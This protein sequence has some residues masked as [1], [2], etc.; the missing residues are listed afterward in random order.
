MRMR[1]ERRDEPRVPCVDLLARHPARLVHQVDEAEVARGEHDDVLTGHVV[2]GALLLVRWAPGRLAERGADGAVVLVTADE[3]RDVGRFERPGDEVVEPVAVSLLEGCALRLAVVGEDD[4]LVRAGCVA[5]RTGDAAELVVELAQRLERVGALQPGVVGDLVV[6]RERR[7]DRGPP[8]HHVRQHR[9]HDQ[10]AHDDAHRRAHEGVDAAAVPARLHVAATRTERGRPLEQHL[11]DE[12]H[13]HPHDVEAVGE[14]RAVARVGPLLGLDPADGED[15]LVGLAGEQVASARA[16]VE[17]QPLVGRVAALELGAVGRRGARHHP[18]VLLLHPPERGNVDVRPE[19]DAGLAGTCLGRKV[20]LPA[21][22]RVPVVG[23]PAGHLRRVAVP[24]RA[25][26][27]GEGEAVDLEEHDARRVG[28][29][30]RPGA[31][32]D[33]LDDAERELAVVV[34][35]GDDLEHERHRRSEEGHEQRPPEPVDAHPPVRQAVRRK[36]H[37]RV[38]HEDREEPEDERQRKPDRGD[39][40]RQDRVERGD[41]RGDEERGPEPVDV[42]AGDDPCR[43]EQPERGD[44]P[45]PHH[46]HRPEAQALLPPGGL[47]RRPG[48]QARRSS[49][50]SGGA[51]HADSMFKARSV[52][53]QSDGRSPG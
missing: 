19:E 52:V 10:V 11:P 27:D 23:Q 40:R 1:G 51:A 21:A 48:R 38:E 12:Q 53:R 28:T 18:R 45:R 15:H 16:T 17:Q 7:V 25:A 43:D 20:G 47:R 30:R 50:R 35:P 22:Q 6:A 24:H 2:L 5:A 3:R 14:E 29:H 32:R 46:V 44:Q 33:A 34:D 41:H 9:L 37:E 42:R 39:D 13:E 8:A 31:A 49:V 36:E 26:Q 4:D